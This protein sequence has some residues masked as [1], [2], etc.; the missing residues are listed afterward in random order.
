M[1]LNNSQPLS[2]SASALAIVVLCEWHIIRACNELPEKIVYVLDLHWCKKNEYQQSSREAYHLEKQLKQQLENKLLI[3]WFAPEDWLPN[4]WNCLLLKIN[5]KWTYTNVHNW[6]VKEERL[7]S[8]HIFA[9]FPL[10]CGYQS[11]LLLK[12]LEFKIYF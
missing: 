12:S 5:S 9:H 3:E 11:K 6:V 10:S 4:W 1:S 8:K 7:I 2:A